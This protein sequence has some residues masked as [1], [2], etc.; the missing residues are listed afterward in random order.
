MLAE[1]QLRLVP[2]SLRRAR[3]HPLECFARPR[4]RPHGGARGGG[5]GG[6]CRGTGQVFLGKSPEETAAWKPWPKI[7]SRR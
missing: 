7:R 5:G 3:K 4:I 2:G 1:K 6:L